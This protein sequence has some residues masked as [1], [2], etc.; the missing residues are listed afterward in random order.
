LLDEDECAG[1]DSLISTERKKRLEDSLFNSLTVDEDGRPC[2]NIDADRIQRVLVKYAQGHIKYETGECLLDA[3]SNVAFAFKSQ[4]DCDTIVLF[5]AFQA[6]TVYPEVASRLMQRVIDTGYY[7]WVDVQ[8]GQY[9]YCVNVNDGVSV[10]I[11]IAER[12]FGEINW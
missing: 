4:L 6:V 3:P 11:V 12:L 9:R 8:C 10:K 7:G 5:E 1:M 2:L